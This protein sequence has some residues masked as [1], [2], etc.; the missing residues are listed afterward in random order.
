MNEYVQATTDYIHV[1]VFHLSE[2]AKKRNTSVKWFPLGEDASL[3]M[4]FYGQDLYPMDPIT[5]TENGFMEPK[6]LAFWR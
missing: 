1:T 3:V 5:E 2:K 6:Y 4:R